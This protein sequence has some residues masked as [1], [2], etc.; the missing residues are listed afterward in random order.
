MKPRSLLIQTLFLTAASLSLSACSDELTVE[1]DSTAAS[2]E[3]LDVATDQVGLAFAP[4]ED[5]QID[6]PTSRP[7][8]KVF[9]SSAAFASYFG[10]TTSKVNW[11]KE[12]VVYY[13]AGMQSTDGHRASLLSIDYSKRNHR[14]EIVTAFESPGAGCDVHSLPELPYV[15]VKFPKQVDAQSVRYYRED[16]L[17]DCTTTTPPS[18]IKAD[19]ASRKG[20][21]MVTIENADR[22]AERYTTWV[23]TPAFIDEAK[24]LLAAG[25]RRVPSFKVLDGTECDGKWSFHLDPVDASFADFTI[26]ICDAVPSYIQANKA[27]WLSKNLRWCP[28]SAKVVSVDDRR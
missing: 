8:R 3:A 20:G 14:L 25:E 5:D 2:V 15:L 13:S 16:S 26:E 6:V 7:V 4:V 17:R 10:H 22:A 12:W 9:K 19:C 21:A 11:S 18:P 27:D 28:W 23:T 1:D 24:R